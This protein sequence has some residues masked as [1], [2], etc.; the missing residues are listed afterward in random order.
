MLVHQ[1]FERDFNA[2]RA[3]RVIIR[4]LPVAHRD[5]AHTVNGEYLLQIVAAFNLATGK[6]GKIFDEYAVYPAALDKSEHFL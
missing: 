4:I 3:V 6:P 2:A 1:E 5:E